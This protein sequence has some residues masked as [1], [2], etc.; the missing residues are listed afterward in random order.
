MILDAVPDVLV[1]IN[2][3]WKLEGMDTVKAMWKARNLPG[4]I[5]SA[6]PDY[7][8][9][10]TSIDLEDYDN[11]AMLAG[12]GNEVKQ[13]LEQNAPKGCT[14]VILDDMPDFLPEQEEHLICT[15]P[16]VGITME[17]AMEAIGLLNW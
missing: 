17:N 3:S 1:V 10:L 2:S 16:R 9:D 15:D 5:H 13:W 4:K 14:Y 8:P 7:V 12:K 11:I 6:T